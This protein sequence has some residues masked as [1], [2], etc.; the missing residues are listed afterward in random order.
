MA[1]PIITEERCDGCEECILVCPMDVLFLEGTLCRVDEDEFC[2]G[3]KVCE[4]ACTRDAL[5]ICD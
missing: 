4:A 1:T 2:T 5:V 3:C